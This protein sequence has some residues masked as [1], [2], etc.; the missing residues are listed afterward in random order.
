[1]FQ[2]EAAPTVTLATGWPQRTNFVDDHGMT[3]AASHLVLAAAKREGW[4]VIWKMHPGDAQGQEERYAKLA[5]MYR[6]PTVV[7]RDQLPYALLATDVIISTG[8]SNVLVE[9]GINGT[10][11]ALF[12]LRGYGFEGEPPWVIEPSEEGVIDTVDRLTNSSDWRDSKRAFIR[13]YAFKADGKSGKRAVRQI[14]GI[15]GV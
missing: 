5:A 1:M 8:P 2:L 10:P 11:P 12:N 3:E 13:R 14:K 4:Q 9:A 15:I 6:V 7:T